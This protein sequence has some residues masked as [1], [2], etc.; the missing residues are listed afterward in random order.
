MYVF[1]SVVLLSLQINGKNVG[2]PEKKKKKTRVGWVESK[3][4]QL[5]LRLE[6]VKWMH[7]IPLAY[8]IGFEST[9]YPCKKIKIKTVLLF[10]FKEENFFLF[11]FIF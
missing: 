9:D 5:V 3:F 10:F 4:R 1:F 2:K 6:G 7:A 11:P 8:S